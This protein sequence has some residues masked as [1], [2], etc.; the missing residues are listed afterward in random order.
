[1]GCRLVRNAEVGGKVPTGG[2]AVAWPKVS[3]LDLASYVIR[4]LF[5]RLSW[6]AWV[7][8]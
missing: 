5:V 1:M 3:G 4:D 8:T 7:D 6:V 2:N